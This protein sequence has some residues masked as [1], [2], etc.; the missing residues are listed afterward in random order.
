MEE[1]KGYM[2]LEVR[3]DPLRRPGTNG[4]H[5]RHAESPGPVLEWRFRPLPA[6]PMLVEEVRV[7][8]GRAPS[9]GEKI[10]R[11]VRAAPADAVLR[12]RVRGRIPVGDRPALGASRLRAI[13]PATMNLE[14]VLVDDRPRS[15]PRERPRPTG[16]MRR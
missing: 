5:A 12:V 6:R 11:V 2:M 4:T 13:T 1:T 3:T 16:G 14:V 7:D 8:D 15:R 9:L 10:E